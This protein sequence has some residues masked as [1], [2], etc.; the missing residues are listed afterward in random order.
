[1]A[2]Q[3]LDDEVDAAIMLDN[4]QESS[5]HHGDNNQLAHADDAVAHSAEPSVNVER[6]VKHTNNTRQDDTQ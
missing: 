3:S 4:L 6:T 1:M 2:C 5:C